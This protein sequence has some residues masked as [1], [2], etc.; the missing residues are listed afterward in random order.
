LIGI[1][2]T[3]GGVTIINKIDIVTCI[4]IAERTVEI[5][6]AA[7]AGEINDIYSNHITRINDGLTQRTCATVV[8]ISTFFKVV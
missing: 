3:N 2:T 4:Q 1:L 8:I 7:D 5:N 6:C